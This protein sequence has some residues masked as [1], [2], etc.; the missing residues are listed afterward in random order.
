MYSQCSLPSTCFF[1]LS[2][3]STFPFSHF[4]SIFITISLGVHSHDRVRVLTPGKDW[5]WLTRLCFDRRAVVRLLSLE[6]LNI[7]LENGVGVG[8][9][10]GVGA[11]ARRRKNESESEYHEG[12]DYGSREDEGEDEGEVEVEVEE[13]SRGE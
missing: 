2:S 12:V 8:V 6:L 1:P 4:S 3:F 10:V 11:S 5:N 9:G 13:D 7:A